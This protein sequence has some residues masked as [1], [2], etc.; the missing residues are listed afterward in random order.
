[1]HGALNALGA[2]RTMTDVDASSGDA[3]DHDKLARYKSLADEYEVNRAAGPG[4]LSPPL[5]S[6]NQLLNN[7]ERDLGEALCIRGG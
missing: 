6:L 4:L 5:F 3:V 2:P 7:S 1:M